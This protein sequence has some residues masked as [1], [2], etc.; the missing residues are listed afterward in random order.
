MHNHQLGNEFQFLSPFHVVFEAISQNSL[1]ELRSNTILSGVK[2]LQLALISLVPSRSCKSPGIFI[3]MTMSVIKSKSCLQCRFSRDAIRCASVT[4]A[5]F[6][7]SIFHSTC[8][9]D[10]GLQ[11]DFRS[12]TIRNKNYFPSACEGDVNIHECG[13]RADKF[14]FFAYNLLSGDVFESVL[15]YRKLQTRVSL[16]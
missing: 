15:H 6:K 14:I 12:D 7:Y 16:L 4:E 2:I 11:R 3:Y 5:C 8:S 9:M 1:F 13:R 10:D